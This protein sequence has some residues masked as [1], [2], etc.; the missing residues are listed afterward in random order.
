MSVFEPT[1]TELTEPFWEATRERR[2]LLQWCRSCDRVVFYPR[3]ICPSC[4]RD[5]LEW[6]PAQ[7]VGTV[8]AASIQNLPGPGRDPADGP[9]VVALV[10]LPEGARVMTNVVGCAPEDVTVGL[11]VQVHWF[12][13]ADGRH[14]PFFEPS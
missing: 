12:P 10:D 9:Y 14:L 7:G 8:Y 6:R 13:L 4:L 5:D 2:L 11:A 1:A 3:D